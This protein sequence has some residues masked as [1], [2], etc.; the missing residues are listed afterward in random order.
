[1]IYFHQ[2]DAPEGRRTVVTE[3]RGPLVGKRVMR[4]REDDCTA[5][6]EARKASPHGLE[7]TA[8]WVT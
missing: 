6:Y 3:R 8:P 7:G 2:D 1:M 4:G 5:Y